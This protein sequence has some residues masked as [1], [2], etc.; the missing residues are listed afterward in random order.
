MTRRALILGAGQIGAAVALRLASEDWEVVVASRHAVPLAG[1]SR[2]DARHPRLAHVALD[3]ED[4]QAAARA[5]Q[6]GADAV[7]DTIAYEPRH[8]D[9]LLAAQDGLGAIVVMSSAAVYRDH[10]G[11]NLD[12]AAVTG[13]PDFTGPISEGQATVAPG[14]RNYSTRKVALERRLLDAADVPVT[15]LRPAAVYG[16]GSRHPREWWF[17]KRML[18]GRPRIPLA[19]RGESRFH[20]TAAANIA[21][22][23]SAALAAPGTR[24]LNAADPAAPTVAEIGAT[25][26][27]LMG[28]A[29]RIVPLDTGDAHGHAGVGLTPWS[30][31]GSFV[32]DTS[33]A[34]ALGYR[35]AT[36]YTASPGSGVSDLVAW[37]RS[38]DPDRW[39][40]HF[41]VLAAYPE[42]PFD[43]AAEDR[44]WELHATAQKPE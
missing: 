25:I 4:N 6:P 19:H 17:V 7:I 20:P 43:Y 40:E 30:V 1:L 5:L 18:D 15:I 32:L 33:A 42:P 12:D 29:G 35:P 28:Y 14:P 39:R 44:H 3:R 2:P 36:D 24:I 26:A 41:P 22:V 31:P 34:S 38:L 16:I 11:R 27:S 37:L 21:A 13:F 10:V 8:A 9:Q 23:V